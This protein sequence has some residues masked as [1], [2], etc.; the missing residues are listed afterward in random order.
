[1]QTFE[2]LRID[3]SDIIH[4]VTVK[5]IE[6][7]GD[8][9]SQNTTFRVD[10]APTNIDDSFEILSTLAYTVKAQLGGD[11]SIPPIPEKCF[12]LYGEGE[13]AFEVGKMYEII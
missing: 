11:G 9:E 13:E 5:A 10:I 12:I 7:L 3:S 4:Q 8:A 1:M 2:I 6:T